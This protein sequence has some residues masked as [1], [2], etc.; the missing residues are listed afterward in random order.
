[1]NLWE[2]VQL[3]CCSL[4]EFKQSHVVH[5]RIRLHAAQ[6]RTA[7]AVQHFPVLM[8][9][10]SPDQLH[11]AHVSRSRHV[12][13]VWC[14]VSGDECFLQKTNTRSSDF[15]ICALYFSVFVLSWSFPDS[16]VLLKWL[17][18]SC[19]RTTAGWDQLLSGHISHMVCS[20][21]FINPQVQISSPQFHQ[22]KAGFPGSEE[23]SGIRRL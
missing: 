17:K 1:M 19:F 12:M 7:G 23:G 21:C 11:T 14:N 2:R 9:S 13:C 22:L 15:H 10:N 8:D 16:D 20:S 18:L 4:S 3:V 6:H 5:V